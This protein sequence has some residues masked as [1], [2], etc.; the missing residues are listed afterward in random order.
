MYKSYFKIGWRNLLKNKGFGMINISGLGIGVSACL[1]ITLFILHEM[2][3]DKQIPN[4][5]NIYRL[6]QYFNVEGKDEWGIHHPAP[7]ASTME[8]DFEEVEKAGRIM[9]NPQRYGAGSNEIRIEG[10]TQQFHE[11]GFAYADQ[12]IL[13]MLHVPFVHGSNKSALTE[14]FSIVFSESKA[15][16]YFR[17]ENPVGK[18][19]YLNGRGESTLCDFWCDER[20]FCKFKFPL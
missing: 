20:L 7:M 5:E 2:S 11:T 16:K 14:P 1:L 12:S 17:D 9:D 18:I 19:I 13:D 3:Y 8:V 10:Q 4:S 15:K 6:T